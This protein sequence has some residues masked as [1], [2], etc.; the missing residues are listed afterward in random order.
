MDNYAI[1]V[2]PNPADEGGGF[3]GLVPDLPGCMSHGDSYADAIVSTQDAIAAW[4]DANAEMGREAPKSGRA[5]E[6][7]RE[8]ESAIRDILKAAVKAIEAQNGEIAYLEDQMDRLMALLEQDT[9]R[10]FSSLCASMGIGR[11]I[12]S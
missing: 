2:V 3:V 7:A 10:K 1:L 12:E 6:R 9:E 5:M 8:R 4:L 11:L